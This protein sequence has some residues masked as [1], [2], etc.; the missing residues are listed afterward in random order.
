MAK[1]TPTTCSTKCWENKAELLSIF[2]LH[3]TATH[4]THNVFVES[5]EQR[6]QTVGPPSPELLRGGDSRE[7]TDR[8]AQEPDQPKTSMSSLFC[9]LLR[10]A[11]PFVEPV[12]TVLLSRPE[13][14]GEPSTPFTLLWTRPSS[15]G[16]KLGLAHDVVPIIWLNRTAATARLPTLVCRPSS[17]ALRLQVPLPTFRARAPLD[18]YVLIAVKCA[19]L[20]VSPSRSNRRLAHA[21]TH[22]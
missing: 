4:L 10:F 17:R 14:Q 16:E 3:T 18:L 9:F 21:C 20:L 8:T 15:R 13:A 7:A 1:S 12:T 6:Q 22:A 5:P 11:F 19:A 2:H